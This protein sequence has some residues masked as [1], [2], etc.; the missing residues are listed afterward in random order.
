[1]FLNNKTKL[2]FLLSL[3][4]NM[5][6]AKITISFLKNLNKYLNSSLFYYNCKYMTL[7]KS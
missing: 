4:I 5:K 6:V 1:M 2:A 3:V 7:L